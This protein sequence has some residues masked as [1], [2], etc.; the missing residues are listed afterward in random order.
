MSTP[1]T[2]ETKDRVRET[3][4]RIFNRGDLDYVDEAY[5]EEMV[6]HNVPHGEDYEGREAFKEWVRELRETFPDFEVELED[7]IVGEEKV[8]TQ[9]VA[10]GTHEGPLPPMNVPATGKEV[11]F[12]GVTV[13]TMD[14]EVATEAWWYYD[15]LGV[16]RQLGIVPETPTA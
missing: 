10:R 3:N 7:V 9:Y 6:M 8:V 11:E 5:A 4:E 12:E 16:L 1:T 14:G 13:H 15:Q 2:E